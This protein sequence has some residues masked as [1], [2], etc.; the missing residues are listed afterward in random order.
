MVIRIVFDNLTAIDINYL[1][2]ILDN[3]IERRESSLLACEI[4]S[5]LIPKA[6]PPNYLLIFEV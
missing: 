4:D 5:M 6:N 1:S 2:R 3:Q